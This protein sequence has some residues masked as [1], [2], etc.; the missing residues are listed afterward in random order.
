MGPTVVGESMHPIDRIAIA[1][2]NNDGKA[3]IIATEERYPGEEPDA[4]L[5]W[6][7]QQADGVWQRNRIVTQYSINNLDI[8]DID[9]DG[10]IDILTAEHKGSALELQLWRN[11]GKGGF[12]KTILDTG[13]EN[14]LGTS[15]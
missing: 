3:D 6:F 15:G 5:W 10:D 11:D 8:T 14:H 12:S 4:N 7:Q 2:M 1:D 13:K 9:K